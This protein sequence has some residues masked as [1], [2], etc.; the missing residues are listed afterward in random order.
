MQHFSH[1]N[2]SFGKR[3][4][5]HSVLPLLSFCHPPADL[6]SHLLLEGAHPS[7]NDLQHNLGQFP[8]SCRYS[9]FCTQTITTREVCNYEGKVRITVG[10]TRWCCINLGL[11]SKTGCLQCQPKH[12]AWHWSSHLSRTEEKITNNLPHCHCPLK[13]NCPWCPIKTPMRSF[14]RLKSSI[15]SSSCFALRVPS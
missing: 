6:Y 10:S 2:N 12:L 5:C 13:E 11:P 7:A 14:W 3:V 4:R 1:P 15:S 8:K 9:S